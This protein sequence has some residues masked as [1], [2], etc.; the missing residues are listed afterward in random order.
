VWL[1]FF[2]VKKQISAMAAASHESK[3]EAKEVVFSSSSDKD[4]IHVLVLN[5]FRQNATVIAER[6]EQYQKRTK[7]VIEW[8][9]LS[10]PYKSMDADNRSTFNPLQWW[11]TD[12]TRLIPHYMEDFDT[13]NESVEYVANYI[14]T[15]SVPFTALFGFSQGGSLIQ[16]LPEDVL[17]PKIKSLIFVG[18]LQ[19][20]SKKQESNSG[21]LLLLP[22]H[23]HPHTLHLGGEQDKLI[24][25]AESMTL[26]SCFHGAV[27]KAHTKVHCIPVT[28]EFTSLVT[29]FLL[30]Q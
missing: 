23:K 13:G 22:A 24:P 19:V 14:R 12:V 17:F 29:D 27:F 30:H 3:T 26:S 25:L 11:T 1:F 28:T 8:H 7:G 6:M 16:M 2:F 4:V 10:A 5:G 9:F 18:S 20:R 21:C 15:S